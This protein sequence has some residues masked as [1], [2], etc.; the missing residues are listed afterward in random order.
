MLDCRR[1]SAAATF[2]WPRPRKLKGNRR[3]AD[4]AIA[5]SQYADT[6]IASGRRR[7]EP[8]FIAAIAAAKRPPT[9]T[10]KRSCAFGTGC[11]NRQVRDATWGLAGSLQA[12]AA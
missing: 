3:D 5:G 7:A 11:A 4:G 8:A 6:R 9:S 1:R 10:T 2:V 12:S